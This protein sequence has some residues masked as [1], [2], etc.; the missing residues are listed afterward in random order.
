MTVLVLA[1]PQVTD[2]N[3]PLNAEPLIVTP[4][5]FS[6]AFTMSLVATAST[7]GAK[8]AP[9]FT[10]TDAVAAG[11][12]LPATSLCVTLISAA[13][14]ALIWSPVNVADHP[15]KASALTV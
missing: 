3:D 1:L 8:G 9:V 14:M 12:V 6:A 15:P 2:I 4:A 5:A 10:T 13:P 7:K 11:P